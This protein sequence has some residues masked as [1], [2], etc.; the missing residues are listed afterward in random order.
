M[1]YFT[2][3]HETGKIV[4]SLMYNDSLVITRSTT[5]RTNDS[6]WLNA[7]PVL[8]DVIIKDNDSWYVKASQLKEFIATN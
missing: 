7:V 2:C 8:I 4:A 6:C 5:D 3:L 1:M